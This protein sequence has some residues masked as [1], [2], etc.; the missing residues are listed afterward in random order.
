MESFGHSVSQRA[1][2]AM[3][4]PGISLAVPRGLLIFFGSSAIFTYFYQLKG[5]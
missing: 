3:H 2:Q 4:L 5:Q 1:P